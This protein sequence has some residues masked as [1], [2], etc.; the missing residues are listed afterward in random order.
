MEAK[1]LIIDTLSATGRENID[2]V[3]NYMDSHGF[4]TARCHKHHHYEGGLADHSWQT[5]LFAKKIAEAIKA[6]GSSSSIN[7]DSVAICALLHD[8]CKCRGMYHLAGHGQ[9]SADML[10]ELG[11]HLSAEEFLAIRFHMRL[12]S[13]RDHPLY[14]DAKR[15]KLRTIIHNCDNLSSTVGIFSGNKKQQIDTPLIMNANSV[16]YNREFTPD[17]ITQLREGEIFVFGSNI[18]GLHGGGAAA[19][20]NA[21]F[22]AEWGVGEGLTG[23]CYALPTME[24]GVEYI[25]SKVQ[26]FLACAREHP[27]LKF[28]VT[29][30]ACGIA[31]F[32]PSKIA[33]LFK[34]AIPMTNVILPQDFVEILIKNY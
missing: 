10:K 27:E 26:N 34:D 14:Q 1:Q 30:I 25:G 20:A 7:P 9:R 2:N 22:G 23:H 16:E 5:Y 11:L 17:M 24:G 13:H 19:I 28:Y 3:I 18:H 15:C 21:K 32:T 4:F 29:R 6:C 31:G 33:P 8:F 12:C